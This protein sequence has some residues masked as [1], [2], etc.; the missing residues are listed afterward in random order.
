MEFLFIIRLLL[1]RVKKNVLVNIIHLLLLYVLTPFVF[2]S[3]YTKV[4]TN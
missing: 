2:T 1:S 3:F 4:D